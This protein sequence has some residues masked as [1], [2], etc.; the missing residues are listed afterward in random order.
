MQCDE[1]KS[2]KKL[3]T[4]RA[5]VSGIYSQILSFLL[6]QYYENRHA[7]CSVKA[8]HDNVVKLFKKHKSG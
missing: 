8:K 6:Y 4:V 7:L 3:I 5:S 1:N 2:L